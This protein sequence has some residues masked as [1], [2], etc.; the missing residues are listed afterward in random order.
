MIKGAGNVIGIILKIDLDDSCVLPLLLVID[1][2]YCELELEV[3][4]TGDDGTSI[5]LL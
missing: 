5:G 1:M 3:R 2:K 4:D